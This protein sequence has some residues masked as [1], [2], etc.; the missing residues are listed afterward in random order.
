MGQSLNCIDIARALGQILE[1]EV[2][3]PEDTLFFFESALGITTASELEH[4]LHSEDFPD[5]ETMY[6]MLLY[7]E[8]KTR[9]AIEPLLEN[10][11]IADLR[12]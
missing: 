3:L 7:P 2:A 6:E 10:D 12:S 8:H 1:K 9:I 11:G 4:A 5:R